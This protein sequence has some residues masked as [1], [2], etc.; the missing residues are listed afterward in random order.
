MAPG[1]S[2]ASEMVQKFFKRDLK[3]FYSHKVAGCLPRV[4]R[5]ETG[6]SGAKTDKNLKFHENFDKYQLFGAE[7]QLPAAGGPPR[8]QRLW[9]T[10]VLHSDKI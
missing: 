3:I 2:R 8:A 4:F 5:S 1:G 10:R 7:N 6:A 9:Y